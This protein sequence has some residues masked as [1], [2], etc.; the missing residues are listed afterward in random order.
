MFSQLWYVCGMNQVKERLLL[1]L[2]CFF[3][4]SVNFN[5]D[6]SQDNITSQNKSHSFAF[7]VYFEIPLHKNK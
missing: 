3:L 6:L 5:K 7:E 1:S 4:F 2:E